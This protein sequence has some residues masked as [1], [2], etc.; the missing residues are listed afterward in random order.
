MLKNK[1]IAIVA[2]GVL[3]TAGIT[4]SALVS[5][6]TNNETSQNHV[7][8][9][10]PNLNNLAVVVNTNV[11]PLVLYSSPNSNSSIESYISVGEMLNYA[12][13]SNPNFY[14]VTVQETG[15]SGYISA[16]DMQIVE[17]GLNKA[18]ENMNRNG[19]VINVTYD[20]KLMSSP[21]VHSQI[22]GSYKNDTPMII[23]G[24][25]DQWYKV[26]IG[27]QTGYMYSE[28]VGIDINKDTNI[29][30]NTNTN[31]TINNQNQ[32]K[33]NQSP[34]TTNNKNITVSEK[35]I[36]S[37]GSVVIPTKSIYSG[38][39]F[40]PQNIQNLTLPNGYELVKFNVYNNGN[41]I[42]TGGTQT[43]NLSNLNLNLPTANHLNTGNL[44]IE[45]IVK[46]IPTTNTNSNNVDYNQVLA[47]NAY[48][49]LYQNLENKIN[50]T[51]GN[52][53]ANTAK[54]TTNYLSTYFS[55]VAAVNMSNVSVKE[56]NDG[57]YTFTCTT[58]SQMPNPTNP[59][60]MPFSIPLNI[61]N[62]TA[63]GYLIITIS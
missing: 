31:T 62:S 33:T 55:P 46:E 44:L 32:T 25:Q 3:L 47:Q 56:L 41:M 7:L 24:K 42:E 11:N 30:A 52:S 39:N 43:T 8:L 28:Y 18:Y 1:I 63:K 57:N 12:P 58:S 19:Q 5:K 50:S 53:N 14:K 29:P 15:A 34:T 27:N 17:S 2:C 16:D 40:N 51:I 35:M 61:Y 48:N 23:L 22:L 21:D 9:T 38:D 45:Y 59:N 20:V 54:I 60:K 13:T 26:K 10:S 37:N 36:T 4:G 49:K 6:K